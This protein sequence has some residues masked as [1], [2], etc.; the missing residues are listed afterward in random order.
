MCPVMYNIRI[1]REHTAASFHKLPKS[2]LTNISPNKS[3]ISVTCRV[4]ETIDETIQL[5]H[6]ITG[7]LC[8]P[9][10][11]I[12]SQPQVAPKDLNLKATFYT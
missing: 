5:S 2:S 12:I 6:E 7:S 1:L 8:S 11:E 3:Y 9:S 10:L 4:Q